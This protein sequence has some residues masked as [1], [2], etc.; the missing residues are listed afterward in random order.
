MIYSSNQRN[1]IITS[2]WALSSV[3]NYSIF[4][5]YTAIETGNPSGNKNVKLILMFDN[6]NNLKHKIIFSYDLDDDVIKTISE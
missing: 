1:A 3:G 4:E 5:Y 2:N 6:D